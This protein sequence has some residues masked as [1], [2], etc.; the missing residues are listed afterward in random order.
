MDILRSAIL[1]G[2]GRLLVPDSAALRI[3]F[4]SGFEFYP[5]N[6]VVVVTGDPIVTELTARARTDRTGPI[7]SEQEFHTKPDLT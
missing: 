3:A 4:P 2:G 7:R 1:E 6:F 5:P